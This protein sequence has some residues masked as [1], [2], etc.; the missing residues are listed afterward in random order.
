MHPQPL[1]LAEFHVIF[2][3]VRR[4][5]KRF[6]MLLHL[7]RMDGYGVE[8][9]VRNGPAL[10]C[11]GA[12]AVK[13]AIAGTVTTLADGSEEGVCEHGQGAPA[14]PRGEAADLVLVQSGQAL[15]GLEGLLHPSSRPGDP[16]Q[17][18][19]RHRDG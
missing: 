19:K 10:A 12:E 15:S 2:G 9:R 7:P 11:R 16:L 18:G 8:P 6:I 5:Q 13:D 4:D 14:G 3:R 17:R 1:A